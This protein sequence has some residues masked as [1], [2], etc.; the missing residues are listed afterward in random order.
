MSLALGI[1]VGSGG[2]GYLS[3]SISGNK[4]RIWDGPK[5]AR[6]HHPSE[7][8]R[9]RMASTFPGRGDSQCNCSASTRSPPMPAASRR[10]QN[11]HAGWSSSFAATVREE[12]TPMENRMNGSANSAMTISPSFMLPRERHVPSPR[13]G[14][15]RRF[16]IRCHWK[17]SLWI[18]CEGLQNREG[19]I[20]GCRLI[21]FGFS[22]D[23][24]ANHLPH[25]L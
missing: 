13:A 17:R 19:L 12:T 1:G 11:L 20:S 23:C 15:R 10:L 4:F 25:Q 9:P 14:T 24:K 6:M 21:V 2:A 18:E 8:R 7:K 3:G 5:T 22:H 16:F